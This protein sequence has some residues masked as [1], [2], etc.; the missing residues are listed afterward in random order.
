MGHRMEVYVRPED[1]AAVIAIA[2][3]YGVEAQVVGRCY[4]DPGRCEVRVEGATG[5]YSYLKG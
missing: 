3:E 5:T 2:E 1:A 4:N